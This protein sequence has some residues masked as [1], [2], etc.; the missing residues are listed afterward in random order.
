MKN[1]KT[2]YPGGGCADLDVFPIYETLSDLPFDKYP[3][4]LKESVA[5]IC[6]AGSAV[7]EILSRQS[8]VKKNDMFIFFPHSLASLKSKSEDFSIRYFKVHHTLFLDIMSGLCRLTPDFFFYMRQN[9]VYRLSEAE[10]ERFFYFLNLIQQRL[11]NTGPR[12]RRESVMQ[13]LRIYYFDLYMHFFHDP[14]AVKSIRHTHKEEIAFHFFRLIAEHYAE[15][16]EVG[17]YADKLCL[18]TKY[19][20]NVVCYVT[21]KPAKEWIVDH[22]LLEIKALLRNFNLDIKEIVMQ[23][24]FQSQSLMSRFFRNHTGMSPSEFRRTL[25]GQN[26]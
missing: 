17:F 14:N 6:T 4:Y 23:T 21:G 16:R 25:S 2:R 1:I 15:S 26:L 12:F 7:L 3:S 19:M 11:E 10:T 22:T 5:G 20:S 8:K 9:F 13:L 18:S 24:N